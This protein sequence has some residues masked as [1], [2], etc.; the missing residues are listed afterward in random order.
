MFVSKVGAYLIGAPERSSTMLGSSG[1]FQ[2]YTNLFGPCI[3]YK[4]KKSFV[5]AALGLLKIFTMWTNELPQNQV[6]IH[7]TS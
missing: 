7:K 3:R 5:G 2:T 4:E 1:P 6:G